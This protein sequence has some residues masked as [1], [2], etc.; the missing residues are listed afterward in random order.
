MTFSVADPD[1][2]IK[3]KGGGGG[4]E[5]H[6]HP[7]IK[8]GPGLQKIFVGPSGLSLVYKIRGRRG[9]SP[10]PGS[11]ADFSCCYQLSH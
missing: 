4:G 7:K 6:L 8:G 5:S 3:G 2:Q 10:S 9:T 11:V 1:L